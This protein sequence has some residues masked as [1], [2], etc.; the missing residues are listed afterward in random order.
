MKCTNYKFHFFIFF[1]FFFLEISEIHHYATLTKLDSIPTELNNNMKLKK[2]FI[3]EF[4][5]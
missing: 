1:L 3:S 4:N 2:I 5:Y